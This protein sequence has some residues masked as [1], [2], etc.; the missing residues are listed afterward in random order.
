[1]LAQAQKDRQAKANKVLQEQIRVAKEKEKERLQQL[2]DLEER[3]ESRELPLVM[4]AV[5]DTNDDMREL[6]QDLGCQVARRQTHYDDTYEKA[7]RY[8]EQLH[9][10]HDNGARIDY[11]TSQYH[12]HK[13]KNEAHLNR[14]KLHQKEKDAENEQLLREMKNTMEAVNAALMISMIIARRRTMG[15]E[16]ILYTNYGT[17]FPKQKRQQ[18]ESQ[19]RDREHVLSLSSSSSNLDVAIR[20]DTILCLRPVLAQG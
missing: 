9:E 11:L 3:I 13:K 17:R 7:T 14:M 6:C 18:S 2:L 19:S 5:V 12:K 16:T 4:A 15:K 10:D 20:I 1:M 8:Y